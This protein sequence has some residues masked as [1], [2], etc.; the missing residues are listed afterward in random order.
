MSSSLVSGPYASAVSIKFTPR[1]TAR[2]RTLSAF[3]RSGGQPQIPSPVIRIAS[4]PRRSTSRSRPILKV[5]FIAVPGADVAPNILLPARIAALVAALI[6]ANFLRVIILSIFSWFEL[7]TS[8]RSHGWHI[9]I[10]RPQN[11]T[12]AI[13]DCGENV[14]LSGFQRQRDGSWS[15]QL[16]IRQRKRSDHV[17][18]RSQ[19]AAIML[20]A[21]HI[22]N[23]L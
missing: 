16:C 12:I 9:K 17:S 19:Y 20:I 2:F 11:Q 10:G 21:R 15:A 1:S 13:P 6:S 7:L 18:S 8:V 5:E 14:N 23:F 22:R 4:K 3:A